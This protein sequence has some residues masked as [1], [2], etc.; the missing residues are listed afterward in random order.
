MRIFTDEMREFIASNAVDRSARELTRLFNERFAVEFSEVQIK[1][2]KKNNHIRSGRRGSIPKDSPS[3]Q[4][5]QE[6]RD[7]IFSNYVGTGPADMAD[8]LNKT[9]GTSYTIKQLKGYYA[10]HKLNSGTSG[11]F[12][13]GHVPFTKGKHIGDL[14]KDPVALANFNNSKFGKGHLPKNWSPVGTERKREGC[15]GYIFVKV[16][17]PNVW[18]LKQ[19]VVWEQH[20]GKIPKGMVVS[21]LDGNVENFDP[22]NLFLISTQENGHLAATHARTQDADITKG[23]VLVYRLEQR[24][25]QR[26]KETTNEG[27]NARSE[28]DTLRATGESQ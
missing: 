3:K 7:Y 20:Y 10:N 13:K 11:R 27:D 19:R 17:E 23:R 2:F 4:Y 12:T 24:L 9:F 28:H 26:L 21:F 18:M 5:P 1:C 8:R 22:S 25:E 6:I 16:A 14:I 15:D